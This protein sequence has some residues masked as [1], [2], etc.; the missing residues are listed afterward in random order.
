MRLHHS[1]AASLSIPGAKLRPERPPE[2][3]RRRGDEIL[4]ISRYHERCA[5]A[6]GGV[7]D[8]TDH[9]RRHM[10]HVAQ[11]HHCGGHT[12]P[13]RAES[14]VQR[15]TRRAARI[16]AHGELAVEADERLPHARALVAKDDDDAGE[17]RLER[18]SRGATNH[19]LAIHV[20]QQLVDGL[21]HAPRCARGEDDARG[22]DAPTRRRHGSAT[23]APATTVRHA[24]CA[25]PGSPRAPT[26]PPVPLRPCRC[27]GPLV[28]R[29]S[30]HPRDPLHAECR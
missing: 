12:G 16:V 9:L 26:A 13:E 17:P 30:T 3:Q 23:S 6:I 25:L 19:R 10:H 5:G 4:S 28:R 29:S 24:R 8:G 22:P 7:H 2:E 18:A 1:L 27:R 14:R 21:A 15:G 20:E 11:H